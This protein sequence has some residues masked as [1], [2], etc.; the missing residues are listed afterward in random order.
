MSIE[1]KIIQE[2]DGFGLGGF[3][4]I[5]EPFG[6]IGDS[7]DITLPD[8]TTLIPKSSKGAVILG[9]G[10]LFVISAGTIDLNQSH[11]DSRGS[12]LKSKRT[13]IFE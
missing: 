6:S 11:I 5:E 4:G 12:V 3:G 1:F 2:G 9:E 10:N 7:Y 8:T 13:L